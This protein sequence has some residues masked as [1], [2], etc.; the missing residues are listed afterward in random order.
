MSVAFKLLYSGHHVKWS[1]SHVREKHIWFLWVSQSDGLWSQHSLPIHLKG[2]ISWHCWCLDAQLLWLGLLSYCSL[3]CFMLQ[4]D[5]KQGC[6]VKCHCLSLRGVWR[7][8]DVIGLVTQTPPPANQ[9]K[10]PNAALC[11]FLQNIK[12]QLRSWK[13]ELLL[14]AFH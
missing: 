5:K 10:H 3:N 2:G 12:D 4:V 7:G 8:L 13:D 14:V 1:G 9:I 6:G 11:L